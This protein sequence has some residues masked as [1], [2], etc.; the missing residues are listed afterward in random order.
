LAGAGRT[1]MLEAIYGLRPIVSGRM[2]LEGQP[3]VLRSP[4]ES[5]DRGVV[6]IPEERKRDGL[7]LSMSLRENMTLSVI[8]R[9]RR[10]LGMDRRAER[11]T[12]EQWM[13]RM[14]VKAAGVE[15]PA[16][17]LSGGNQQKVVF[18][19]ALM[20]EPKLFLCDEPTQ[21]V[22]VVT[23]G[24]IHR[25]LREQAEKGSGILLVTSDLQEMLEIADRLYILREGEI[26]AELENDSLT[27]EQV[28]QLCFHPLKGGNQ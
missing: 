2:L 7:I 3:V 20:S 1:E 21:A 8:D 10:W 9:F 24:E 6:L 5:L 23:R 14:S 27:P 16:G 25:L 19:K 15:Q 26:V 13:Q 4:R 22:D 17:E 18:A 12:A 11:S 28:L